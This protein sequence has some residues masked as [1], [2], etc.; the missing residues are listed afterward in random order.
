MKATAWAAIIVGAL[1]T[2]LSLNWHQL[3]DCAPGT[4]DCAGLEPIQLFW[5][6]L[7]LLG[8]GLVFVF[9]ARRRT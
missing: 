5:F 7:I 2:L 9:A 1:L 6:G 8:V 3:S 4:Q